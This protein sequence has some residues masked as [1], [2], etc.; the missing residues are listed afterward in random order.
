MEFRAE[1]WE[2]DE[3]VLTVDGKP[4]GSTLSRQN[5]AFLADWLTANFE[6]LHRATPE[7]APRKEAKGACPSQGS[8]T[9]GSGGDFTTQRAPGQAGQKEPER[10]E[11]KGGEA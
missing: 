9:V 1:P 11:P 5:A 3:M 4:Y 8:Y 7:E 6:S 10:I 2:A